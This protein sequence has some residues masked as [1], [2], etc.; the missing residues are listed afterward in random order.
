[1]QPLP[2][3]FLL[4]DER[5][6]CLSVTLVT[7]VADYLNFI[8][9][10][11]ENR[12]G[13]E[14]QRLPLKTKTAI[15]IR[16][17]MV[18]DLIRGAVLPPIVIGVVPRGVEQFAQFRNFA[19]DGNLAELAKAVE[20]EEPSQIAVIDGMQRTTAL[21]EAMA[22]DQASISSRPV[23][24]EL[25][26]G[27]NTNSLIYRM[28]VLNTGQ[29]PWD[30]KRQLET[31]Y[32]FLLKEIERSVP[33]VSVFKLDD[34]SRRA[35]SGQYQSSIVIES[36]FAFTSRKPNVDIKERVAEDFARIDATD[37]ASDSAN[38]VRFIE[39]LRLL[40]NLDKAFSRHTVH[41]DPGEVGDARFEEG[42]DI[43]AVRAAIVGFVSAAAVSIYGDPGFDLATDDI[44]SRYALLTS[45]VTALTEKLN[46]MD[47]QAVGEFLELDILGE[48]LI[49]RTGGVGD[50]ERE[51]FHKAFLSAMK[52]GAELPNMVPCWRA[53]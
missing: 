41:A 48:R 36:Y 42:K 32:S 47:P 40:A 44:S 26:I 15:K 4:T 29:V 52:Y 39:I 33:D 10:S 17:R 53:H 31:V 11:Y 37:S 7:T 25:W 13:L 9:N 2:N 34:R 38:L 24:L 35:A 27:E 14:G 18:S 1:M 5:S 28:L 8:G 19:Q 46:S 49:G 51:V 16:T 6:S 3:Q 43:F 12:G 50:Y 45:R 30:L 23:R 21:L 20:S 22:K